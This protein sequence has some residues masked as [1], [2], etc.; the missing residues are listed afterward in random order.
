MNVKKKQ[1]PSSIPGT[2]DI[3]RVELSNGIV[4]LVR[5]NPNSL[6]VNLRGFLHAGSLFDSDE[7]LGL[8]DFVASA[9]M[10]GSAKREFQAIYESLESIGASLGFNGGTHTAGFGGRS[11]AEDLGLLL[12]LLNEALRRP[13]FPAGQVERLR[14]QLLTGL[15]LR[16]QDTRDMASLLFD[17]MVYRQH[18]YSRAEE[19]HPETVGAITVDALSTFHK[20][21]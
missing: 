16:A 9:L 1:A 5:E 15:A 6:S 4:V 12:D 3:T 11:L 8:A 19:G 21:H 7:K 2:D 10:R 14:A 20:N 17:E 18:P 13:T